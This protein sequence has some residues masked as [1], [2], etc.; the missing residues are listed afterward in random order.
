[1]NEAISESRPSISPFAPRLL[2]L[3]VEQDQI[4]GII[5]PG[6]KTI[7]GM[8]RL[9]GVEIHIEDSGKVSI[10]SPN[11]TNAQK[12]KDYI[13]KLTATP[14]VGETYDGVITKIMDFG[15]F[16][17]ILPG[18]EGLL[19]ISQIDSKRVNKVTDYYKEG[20]KV[21][22]KLIKIENGKYSL[23]RKELLKEAAKE[24]KQNNS[25]QEN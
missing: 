19:H 22:V 16:V 20:D 14:E 21:T 8:Q 12:C 3:Q 7:Q 6:G 15:A 2:N 18:K 17:E 4:G 10:A 13:K 9:F 5:G 11:L 23:S 24:N 25:E 1:M